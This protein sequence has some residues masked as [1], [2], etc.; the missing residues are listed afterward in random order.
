MA[1]NN[2]VNFENMDRAALP[3]EDRHSLFT[4]HPGS[5][6]LLLY[7]SPLFGNTSG[8]STKVLSFENKHKSMCVY[9][10]VCVSVSECV[11]MCL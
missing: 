8:Q 11:C 2:L 3:E 1:P 9:V 5:V 7:F 10:S 4:S 6:C